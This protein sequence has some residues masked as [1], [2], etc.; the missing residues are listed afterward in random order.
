MACDGRRLLSGRSGRFL[1]FRSHIWYN[2]RMKKCTKC[3]K[4]KPLSEFNG[5]SDRGYQYYCRL[6]A[7]LSAKENYEEN[8]DRY[9]EKARARKK[10]LLDRLNEIKSV[11]C[12]DCK[13]S[14]PPIC[15][16]FDHLPE[17]EKIQDIS[18]MLKRKMAWATIE[19]EVKKCEVVCSNCHR[20]RTQNRLKENF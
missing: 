2:N 9:Y 7:N 4:D 15:M 3:G 19:A 16:D 12:A 6:C 1:V 14:F 10:N 11:P 18:K 8:K 5:S 13:N 17:F 20:I